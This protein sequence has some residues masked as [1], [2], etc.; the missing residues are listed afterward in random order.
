MAAQAFTAKGPY[1]ASIE[2]EPQLSGRNRLTSA[3]RPILA[4]PHLLLVGGLNLTSVGGLGAVA[5]IAALISWF[6]LLFT[7]KQPAGLW[8]LQHLYLRWRVRTL[9][10]ATLLVD[11]YPPFGDSNYPARLLLTAPEGTRDRLSIGLRLIYAIPQLMVLIFLLL[12]WA[13]TTLFAW[14]AILFTGRMPEGLAAFGVGVLRWS[15][16]VEAYMLLMRDEYP[17]FSLSA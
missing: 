9:T 6:A 13:V 15:V 17:P 11:N 14:F 2:V 5:W 3:F 10:Y 16:R 8:D 7:G 4:I 1:P 12:A